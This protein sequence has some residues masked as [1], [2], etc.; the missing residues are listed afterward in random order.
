MDRPCDRI[1][2]D[3][4]REHL[5]EFHGLTGQVAAAVPSVRAAAEELHCPTHSAQD[6][7]SKAVSAL[8]DQIGLNA[9]YVLFGFRCEEVSRSPSLFVLDCAE[10]RL[11]ADENS[12]SVYA[13][14]LLRGC[15]CHCDLIA[16]AAPIFVGRCHIV[17]C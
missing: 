4:V 2:D 9:M 17:F 8:I 7:L 1:V 14:S 5:P 11:D 13:T 3:Q 15:Q 16:A 12:L 10:L 6:V